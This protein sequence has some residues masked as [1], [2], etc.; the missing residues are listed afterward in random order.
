MANSHD[1][2]ALAGC[3]QSTVSRVF[4]GAPD[5]RPELA[6]RVR[7]AARQLNYIPSEP[8][9][10]LLS[11]RTG[12]VALVVQ[13][14]INP[15]FALLADHCHREL[16]GHGYRATIVES[17]AEG[18]LL[19]DPTRLLAG[20]DGVIY[21][22]A[23]RTSAVPDL[24]KPVVL[25]LRSDA[26]EAPTD[27]VLPDHAMGAELAVAHLWDE[28]GHRRI[29]LL[30]ATPRLTAG[31]AAAHGF[32]E[33]LARRDDAAEGVVVESPM[34]Y[35]AGRAAA[36]D[37]LARSSTQRPT[38][39]FCADDLSACGAI[40]AARAVGLRVPEDVSVV[41]F[42]DFPMSAWGAYSLTTVAVPHEQ[43]ARRAI[44]LLMS[45]IVGAQPL[46]PPRVEHLPVSLVRRS[47]TA[48]PPS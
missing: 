27:T 44:T 7:E 16:L 47:S 23:D 24:G 5:V 11:G 13:N 6:E 31:V 12:R 29:A 43:L 35:E 14:L 17:D 1:V 46:D 32:R 28:L 4:R 36:T 30:G 15:A 2:A 3:S 33:A 8:A 48:A 25:L 20:V 9:R 45:R 18:G 10:A 21:A 19:A 41:G 40:D 39:F 42:D 34:D 22:S 26:G 38:A 37:L